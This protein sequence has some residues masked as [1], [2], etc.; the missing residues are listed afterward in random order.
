MPDSQTEGRK[1]KCRPE[2]LTNGVMWD[3]A[4]PDWQKTEGRTKQS[5]Q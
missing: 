5:A 1:G 2:L 4:T 3:Q